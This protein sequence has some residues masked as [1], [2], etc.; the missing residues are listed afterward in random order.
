MK[1]SIIAV[2]VL[3]LIAAACMAGI[4]GFLP[5]FLRNPMHTT[6]RP[7]PEVSVLV[8]ARDLTAMQIVDANCI[9]V[10]TLPADD[11]P[12]ERL[13]DKVQAIGKVL[14]LPM[15]EGQAF[16]TASFV[17]EGSGAQLAAALPSGKRAMAIL[18]EHDE[19]LRSLIYPGCIVDV[20]ASKKT[21]NNLE[22]TSRALL[23]NVQ[24]I[25]VEDRTI[26]SAEKGKLESTVLQK[27]MGRKCLVTLMVDPEQARLLQAAQRD[28]SVSLAMRNPLDNTSPVE[29]ASDE[30]TTQPAVA[31]TPVCEPGPK[32]WEIT[33]IRDGKSELR[34]LELAGNQ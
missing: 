15:N 30:P 14:I 27:E 29:T 11:A 32:T 19:S 1:F 2:I 28:G 6:T 23:Q 31:P 33:I 24:V 21:G 10:K 20:L 12:K 22:A 16:T 7:A 34:K 25:A 18:L 3:G 13:S 5:T 4:V 17:S 8:A 9:A 26:V